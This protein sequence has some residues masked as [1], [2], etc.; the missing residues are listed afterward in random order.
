MRYQGQYKEGC[1]KSIRKSSAKRS[2]DLHHAKQ[3]LLT[4]MNESL[5][6]IICSVKRECNIIL[7]KNYKDTEP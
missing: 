2:N 4:T 6:I 5:S 7:K 3:K 1:Y